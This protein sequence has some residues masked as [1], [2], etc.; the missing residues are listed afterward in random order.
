SD[1]FD[2]ARIED[3]LAQL[4]LLAAAAARAPGTRVSEPSLLTESTRAS[5]PDPTAPLAKTWHGSVPERLA[6]AAR[7]HPARL[8]VRDRFGEWSYAELERACSGLA[9]AL[10][11]GGVARGDVVAIRGPRSASLVWAM[12]AVLRSGAAFCLLDPM[13]PGS[14]L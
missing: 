3:A 2:P 1:I 10:R 12:L 9:A 14:R 4:E 6:A 8:A 7:R 5:L 13:Y 11:A